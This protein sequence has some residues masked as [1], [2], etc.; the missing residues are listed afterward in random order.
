[1]VTLKNEIHKD[2]QKAWAHFNRLLFKNALPPCLIIL[3]RKA[4]VGGHFVNKLWEHS[5]SNIDQTDEISLN[6]DFF[7]ESSDEITLAILVHEMCHQWQYRF[8]SP[9][10]KGYHNKEFAIQMESVGL[11]TSST[12]EE[13]GKKVGQSMGHYIIPEGKY[14]KAYKALEA[15][16]FKILWQ[17]ESLTAEKKKKKEK[18]LKT[19]YTCPECQSNVWGKDGLAI[20]CLD[21]QTVY[22]SDKR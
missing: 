4:K 3:N 6:P 15:Q 16:D 10:R 1:L 7:K 18:A 22:L 19:K 2:L 11:Q 5:D 14:Q 9:A 12:G 8:G 20:G 13:G 21:C 17:P